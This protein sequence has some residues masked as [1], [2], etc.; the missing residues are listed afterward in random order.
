MAGNITMASVSNIGTYKPASKEALRSQ[1]QKKEREISTCKTN[2]SNLNKSLSYSNKLVSKLNND[3]TNLKIVLE[4]L[5]KYFVINKKTGDNGKVEK[6]IS[7]LDKIIKKLNNSIIPEI[8]RMISEQ[9]KQR[10]IKQIQ[11]NRLKR[12]YENSL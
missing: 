6:I 9:E 11:L 8:K 5:K 10:D 3:Q 1:I 2:I 12:E 7:E 4:N